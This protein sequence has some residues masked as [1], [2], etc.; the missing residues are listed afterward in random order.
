MD[1]QLDTHLINHLET[2]F[3]DSRF[4]RVD[5]DVPE[6]LIS[7]DEKKESKLAPAQEDVLRPLLEGRFNGKEHFSVM[8]EPMDES[9][10]QC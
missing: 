8:F 9:G 2:K 10:A 3:K 7:R 6:K 4:V 5:S 1:G